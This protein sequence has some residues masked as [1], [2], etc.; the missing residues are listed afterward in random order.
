MKS[1]RGF[2][3]WDAESQVKF[4]QRMAETLATIERLSRSS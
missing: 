1:G 3:R 4:R 2:Y